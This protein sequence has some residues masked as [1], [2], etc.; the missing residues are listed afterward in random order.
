M[1]VRLS[2]SR[3][4]VP[5]CLAAALLLAALPADACLLAER[6]RVVAPSLTEEEIEAIAHGNMAYDPIPYDFSGGPMLCV[7]GE[8]DIFD[9]NNID[10]YAFFPPSSIG[11]GGGTD[12]WGW[13]D[14]M[15]GSEYAMLARTNGTAFVNVTDP[16]NPVYLG[17]LP[18][19]SG[20]SSWRD[21]KVYSN[22]AYIVADGQPHGMQVFDLTQL[23]TVSSPPVTFSATNHYAG[24]GSAHNIVINEDTGFAYAV[25]SSVCSGGL[26]MVDLSDPLNPVDA[27][28]FSAD[29]YT[30]DAQ[31]VIYDGPDAD[32]VGS[33]LCFASNED[34]VTVVDVTNKSAPAQLSRE[35]YAGSGYT[36]QGWLTEDHRYFVHDDEFDESFGG[37]NTRT[38]VWDMLDIDNPVL[39]GFWD[40]AGSAIDHNQ[41]IVGNRTYQAN[42]RRGLRVLEM[43]DPSTAS[44]TEIA[45]FDSYPE[46]DGNGSEGAWSVYPFFDSGTLI[47]SDRS[48]GLFILRMRNLEP[49]IFDDG[50]ESGDTSAWTSA[51]P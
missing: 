23:R 34:T 32:H 24:F 26:E 17:N 20:T 30:H 36:H 39:A 44:F 9:C 10:L 8:V 29:G 41:Y 43:T 2:L 38:Y 16:A 6:L 35:G 5:F 7:D 49:E 14:P 28:C 47:L 13:T 4:L 19:H 40:A 48:R 3:P 27:G 42:Y 15:T 45:F 51:V 46:Q 25:G 1:M 50:F 31:C 33:E 18:S 21:I 37:H 11:G 12:L 22:H